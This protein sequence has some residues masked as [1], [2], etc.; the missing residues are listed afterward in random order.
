MS[1]DNWVEDHWAVHDTAHH[2]WGAEKGT[3]FD[4]VS[5]TRAAHTASAVDRSGEPPVDANAEASRIVSYAGLAKRHIFSHGGD[6]EA[7]QTLFGATLN[8]LTYDDPAL[9]RPKV[10]EHLWT[11]SKANDSN[12]GR[13]AGAPKTSLLEAK[14]AEWAGERG[15]NAYGTTAE[16]T[17]GKTAREA[18]FATSAARKSV[19]EDWQVGRRAGG[20]CARS[21][22]APHMAIGLRK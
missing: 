4:A 19:P 9:G 17:L 8:E 18:D 2:P 14:R 1:I 10:Q 20:P 6:V 15:N 22:D 21:F 11:G 3:S 5:T 13:G 7:G 12:V 16:A